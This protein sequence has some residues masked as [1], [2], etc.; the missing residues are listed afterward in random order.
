[1][2]PRP[3]A[4]GVVALR[5]LPRRYR[6]L[7]AGLRDDESPDALARRVGAGSRSALDHIAS[8]SRTLTTAHRTLDQVLVSDDPRLDPVDVDAREGEAEMQPSG[9][10][11]E[12]LLELQLDSE[13][14]ADRAEHVSAAEWS[15]AGRYDDGTTVTAS[16]V[17]WKA[18]DKAVA[19]LESA[20]QTL[21]EARTQR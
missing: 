7:F 19:H 1:M 9:S 13:R 18:V 21:Q 20:E 10:L 8:A 6:G 5:S 14:L 2:A 15:R 3:P 16:D 11:E 4:D 17:L 12:R